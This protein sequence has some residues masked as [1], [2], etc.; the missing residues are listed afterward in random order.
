MSLSLLLLFVLGEPVACGALNSAQPALQRLLAGFGILGHFI[1]SH[2][3]GF[4]ALAL[5]I[6]SYLYA[7]TGIP[8]L[9]CLL[10]SCSTLGHGHGACTGTRIGTMRAAR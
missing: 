8:L 7:G 9:Y 1:W 5:D 6:N 2:S 4:A 3:R 10:L